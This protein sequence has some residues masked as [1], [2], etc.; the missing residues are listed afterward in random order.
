V[1]V[2]GF[3]CG[4]AVGIFGIGIRRLIRCLL[5]SRKMPVVDA[6]CGVVKRDA[7]ASVVMSNNRSCVFWMQV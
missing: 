7:G 1:D 6:A 2:V 3:R 5:A 4:A